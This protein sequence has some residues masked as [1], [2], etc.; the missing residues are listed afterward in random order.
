VDPDLLRVM[1]AGRMMAYLLRQRGWLPLHASG[2]SMENQAV[3]FMGSSGSGKSTTAAAFHA[4]GHEVITDDVSAVRVV[5]KSCLVRGAGS[6]IRLLGDARTVF[7]GREPKGVFQWD[8][9]T[10]D[11]SPGKTL[12][13]PPVRR[14]YLIEYGEE[15]RT[16]V[17]P[18]L[19]AVAAL[20]GNCFVKRWR[21]DTEAL[22]A[23]LSDCTAVAGAVRV[24]RLVRPRSL[25]ALP[26]LVSLVESEGRAGG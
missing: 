6:R 2:I 4:R 17:I 3:L 20:S 26:A 12:D 10:F 8:K 22:G 14:I 18:L 25:D 24:Y 7:D 5:D 23:H 19:T 1:L 21:M 15:L 11:L 9:H 16:E 13:P